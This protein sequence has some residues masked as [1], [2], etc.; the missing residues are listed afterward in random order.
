MVKVINQRKLT[1]LENMFPNQQV[2][3]KYYKTTQNPEYSINIHNM[4]N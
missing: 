1:Y 4:K 3:K 2:I